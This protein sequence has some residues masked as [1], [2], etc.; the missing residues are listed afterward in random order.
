M[1]RVF[2]SHNASSYLESLGEGF[3][4]VFPISALLPEG[5]PKIHLLAPQVPLPGSSGIS[6]IPLGILP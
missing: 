3:P 4:F 6:D 2:S 1:A 5:A